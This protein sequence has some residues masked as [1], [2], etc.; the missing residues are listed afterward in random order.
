VRRTLCHPIITAGRLHHSH[1][2]RNAIL[3]GP[4]AQGRQ[5]W[6][7]DPGCCILITDGELARAEG[8]K[9]LSL[10][11]SPAPGADLTKEP[12]RWDQR[13]FTLL[14]QPRCETTAFDAA[15]HELSARVRARKRGE[16]LVSLTLPVHPADREGG[17]GG[18]VKPVWTGT[19][20]GTDMMRY[21][22]LL[23]M[24]GE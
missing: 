2:Y 19:S 14:I 15:A 12:Y 4:D 1:G 20:S 23:V 16:I 6:N 7:L 11:V 24:P 3:R 21:H 8:G 9:S 22:A 10:T 18:E 13:L 5:P 17:I